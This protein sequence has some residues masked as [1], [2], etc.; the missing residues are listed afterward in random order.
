MKFGLARCCPSSPCSVL[1][2]FAERSPS[3]KPLGVDDLFGRPRGASFADF[4]DARLI[5]PTGFSSSL[6]ED[7]TETRTW[8][9]PT[10]GGEASPLGRASFLLTVPLVT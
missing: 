4:L 10:A 5:A 6:K 7:K 9:I 3:P 8:M 2:L 1:L